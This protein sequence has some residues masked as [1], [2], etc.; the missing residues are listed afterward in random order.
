MD[1]PAL[2]ARIADMFGCVIKVC[3]A[4]KFSKETMNAFEG[5]AHRKIVG[6]K[7][8]ECFGDVTISVVHEV[9]LLD[10]F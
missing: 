10:A 3:H 2:V 5:S 6:G 9:F 4:V 1:V 7:L 8:S